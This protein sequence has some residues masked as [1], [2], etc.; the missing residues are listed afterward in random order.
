MATPCFGDDLRHITGELDGPFERFRDPGLLGHRGRF[1]RATSPALPP[2]AA[3]WSALADADLA[4]RRRRHRNA[5]AAPP[6]LTDSTLGRN[7]FL[8][9]P[10]GSRR[11][12]PRVGRWPDVPRF[13]SSGCG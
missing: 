1:A 9:P 11:R 2:E 3:G 4:S 5:R 10:G 13:T 8:P 7:G 12:L 6:S